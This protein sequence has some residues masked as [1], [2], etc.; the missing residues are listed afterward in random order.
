[1]GKDA[2]LASYRANKDSSYGLWI[3]DR[4][5]GTRTRRVVD[6]PR[7]HELG[8]V[9]L[10]PRPVP[11]GRSS[12][13]DPTRDYGQF[14]CLDSYRSDRPEIASV[15]PGQI[16]KVRF[17]RGLPD[18][19]RA[20][21]P[22]DSATHATPLLPEEV[23]GEI[24]VEADGSFFV[25]VPPEVPLRMETLDAD[26]NVLMSMKRWLWVMP[27]EGRGCIGCHE[28]REMVPPNFHPAALRNPAHVLTI[29]Q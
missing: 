27:R 21:A 6:D 14:Y 2:L 13:V 15:R 22:A 18:A 8:A 19:R 10:A 12:I 3:V 7:W 26:G 17:I 1:M 9:T 28:D 16:S 25:D 4:N 20:G 23:L 29:D 24:P 11:A 5:S